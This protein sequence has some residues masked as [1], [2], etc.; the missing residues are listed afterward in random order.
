MSCYIREHQSIII[1]VFISTDGCRPTAEHIYSNCVSPSLGYK[2]QKI[3]FIASEN[4]A[5]IT[6]FSKH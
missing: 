2:S 4:V 1:Q 3:Q 5:E 6:Q